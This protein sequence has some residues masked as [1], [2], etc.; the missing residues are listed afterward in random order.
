VLQGLQR[1]HGCARE[2]RTKP[3]GA[4]LLQV[5]LLMLLARL[6]LLMMCVL[7][8]LLMTMT[9]AGMGTMALLMQLLLALLSQLISRPTRTAHGRRAR[10]PSEN[11]LW[12]GVEDGRESLRG[13]GHVAASPA[14]N[15]IAC[16][17][18]LRLDGSARRRHRARTRD[19]GA[20][21]FTPLGRLVGNQA[22]RTARSE[23]TV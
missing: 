20:L 1:P 3:R 14:G 13:I 18:R 11:G 15:R 22:A 12:R 4:R 16:V 5:L 17:K 19:V 8:M 23:V 6:V 10:Q 7:L 2:P 21:A 9:R